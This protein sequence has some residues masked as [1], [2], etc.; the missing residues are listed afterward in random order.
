MQNEANT[1]ITEFLNVLNNPPPEGKKKEVYVQEFL[2]ANS[3]LIPIYNRLNHPL[4]FNMVLSK[5]PI[6]KDL[7]PDFTYITKSSTKWV[8][9]FVE[10][11]SP[12]KKMFKRTTG[13][14]D[15]HSNY[16]Q[17]K[18]QINSWK[19][20]LNNNKDAFIKSI[21]D[22]LEPAALR[23]NP[24]E[25]KY[26]LIYGRSKEKEASSRFT[27][28]IAREES[29]TGIDI[30]TYDS[31]IT[32]YQSGSS[33]EKDIVKYSNGQFKFKRMNTAN[34]YILGFLN[35][36]K[37]YLTDQQKETLKNNGYQIDSWDDGELLKAGFGKYVSSREENVDV[38]KNYIERSIKK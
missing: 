24:C 22:L 15:T 6:S 25:F 3:Q 29:E 7:I 16:T 12:D 21:I 33:H 1:L 18:N 26:M 20:Y 31:I 27:E 19:L 30:L 36:D 10:L 37:F 35:N 32:N 4:H 23:D 28:Y 2:E 34:T 11:E 5:F 8:I 13:Q 38:I 9:T 17:A 14:V